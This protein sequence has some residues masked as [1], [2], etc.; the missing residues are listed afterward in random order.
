M[1]II[2]CDICDKE[3]RPYRFDCDSETQYYTLIKNYAGKEL[4]T[5]ICNECMHKLIDFVKMRGVE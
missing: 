5:D 3:M 4:G 1:K 2:R